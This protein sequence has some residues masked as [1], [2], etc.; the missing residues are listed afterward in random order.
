MPSRLQEQTDRK[1]QVE[2]L[3]GSILSDLLDYVVKK[4]SLASRKR[5]RSYRSRQGE[6]SDEEVVI[7]RTREDGELTSCSED[8][9]LAAGVHCKN[10]LKSLAIARLQSVKRSRQLQAAYATLQEWR[11]SNSGR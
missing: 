4:A 10:S 6:E 1:V 5:K 9:K 7:V 2:E 8:D 3:V 11:A